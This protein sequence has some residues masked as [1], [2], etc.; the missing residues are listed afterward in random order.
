VTFRR[1]PPDLNALLGALDARGVLFVVT[2]SVA[3][4][5]HGLSLEPG[6][7]DITPS[8]DRENLERLAR[9]L[10]D[11]RARLDPDEPFGRWETDA[12]GERRWVTFEPTDADREGR[13]RWR[14]DPAE[15]S[16]FDHVLQT[17]HG[18]LDVVPVLSGTYEELRPRAIEVDVNGRRVRVESIADQLATLTVPRRQKD[19]E[20]VRG[21][22][23]LQRAI[24]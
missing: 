17:R 8:L 23:T 15:I 21:L 11:L 5:L 10:D 16:T 9:S 19:I 6:D 22:R 20:R 18:T 24:G 12:Q 14:P 1:V 4:L 7:L 13:A 3:A 2:G